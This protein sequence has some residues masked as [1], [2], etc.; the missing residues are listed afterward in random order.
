MLPLS[1]TANNGLF[2][3][4]CTGLLSPAWWKS[5][6]SDASDEFM[7]AWMSELVSTS[8]L[9]CHVPL[10]R[11]ADFHWLTAGEKRAP[12]PSHCTD[13]GRHQRWYCH[14]YVVRQI[15]ENGALMFRSFTD[16][17]L[18][19]S[20]FPKWRTNI[21]THERWPVSDIRKFQHFLMF[22]HGLR[23]S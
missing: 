16:F 1:L 8:Y 2:T 3:L 5:S 11:R 22:K 20:T 14:A 4:R 9:T 10:C 6:S 18:P 21:P 15:P 19:R 7:R 17:M 23:F 12:S 13:A